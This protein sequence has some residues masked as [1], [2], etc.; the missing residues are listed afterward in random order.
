MQHGA[1]IVQM[2]GFSSFVF[3]RGHMLVLPRFAQQVLK[4]HNSSSANV[5]NSFLYTPTSRATHPGTALSLSRRHGELSFS[6]HPTLYRWHLGLPLSPL[7]ELQCAVIIAGIE[8]TAD[9]D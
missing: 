2:Y 4:A 8:T 1:P 7:W 5:Y 6:P 3:A 9:D